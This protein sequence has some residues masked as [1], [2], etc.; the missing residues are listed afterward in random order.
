VFWLNLGVLV[1]L[2]FTSFYLG[3]FAENSRVLALYPLAMQL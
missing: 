2:F 1:I 3:V